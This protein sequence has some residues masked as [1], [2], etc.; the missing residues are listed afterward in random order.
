M[1]QVAL[2]TIA[3]FTLSFL[4]LSPIFILFMLWGL[5]WARY[6]GISKYVNITLVFTVFYLILVFIPTGFNLVW[7]SFKIKHKRRK[8]FVALYVIF[9]LM[10]FQFLMNGIFVIMAGLTVVIA[11]KWMNRLNNRT[12]YILS[13]I[14]LSIIIGLSVG[15]YI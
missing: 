5:D 1:K 11:N 13:A 3:S 2:N 10:S 8:L 15:M 6:E 12:K 14:P 7:E 4:L 9:I